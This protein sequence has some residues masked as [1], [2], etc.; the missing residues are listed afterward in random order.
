MKEKESFQLF[1]EKKLNEFPFITLGQN[2]SCSTRYMSINLTGLR[3]HSLEIFSK[4]ENKEITVYEREQLENIYKSQ[5][6]EKEKYLS[7]EIT[8]FKGFMKNLVEEYLQKNPATELKELILSE[9]VQA[10]C[11][12]LENLNINAIPWTDYDR[13][14]VIELIEVQFDFTTQLILNLRFKES[15]TKL[16]YVQ[17]K[18]YEKFEQIY[19]FDL[20]TQ[21]FEKEVK[22]IAT[23]VF[24]FDYD[25]IDDDTEADILDSNYCVIKHVASSDESETFIIQTTDL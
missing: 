9:G 25:E 8:C 15:L 6:V 5:V 12:I 13:M 23:D 19:W 22:N 4:K 21:E 24:K 2:T 14:P 1:T 17:N 18:F 10:L 3:N 16:N 7:I 11:V 20:V